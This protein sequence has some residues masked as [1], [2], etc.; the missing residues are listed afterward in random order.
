MFSLL[1]QFFQFIID[2]LGSVLS[3]VVDILPGSP[4]TYIDSAPE[5]ITNMLEGIN[6][7]IPIYNFVSILQ[8]WLVAVAVYYLYSIWARWAKAIQ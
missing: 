7:F 3:F 1:A 5:Q 6:Y 8:A 4:F 2:S